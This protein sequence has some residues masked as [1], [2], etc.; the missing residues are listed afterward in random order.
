MAETIIILALLIAILAGILAIVAIILAAVKSSTQGPQGVPGQQGPK[1]NKGCTGPMGITG[2]IGP[3]GPTGDI[4]STGP[5]GP[6]GATGITGLLFGMNR[7]QVSN[8]ISTQIGS[9]GDDTYN[10]M[11]QNNSN[12]NFIGYNAKHDINTVH[13]IID[14]RNCNIGDTYSL[15]NNSHNININ[16]NP[17]GFSNLNTSGISDNYVLSPRDINTALLFI[18]VGA[19]NVEKNINIL[20]SSIKTY[21][22][23]FS[24]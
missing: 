2:D 15:T 16:L 4:G 14:A 1:G 23:D 19:S 13:V 5:T 3:T 17:Q 9:M 22:K 7:T 21:N 11:G 18:T 10:F 24:Y 6:I 12:I 20:Y 8:S